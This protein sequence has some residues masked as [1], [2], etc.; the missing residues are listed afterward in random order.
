MEVVDGLPAVGAGVHG[1]AVAVLGETFLPSEVANDDPHASDE[2]A[3]LAAQ[4]KTVRPLEGTGKKRKSSREVDGGFGRAACLRSKAA[5]PGKTLWQRPAGA[6]SSRAG[7]EAGG[8][9]LPACF[10][11]WGM[12]TVD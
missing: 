5:G 12:S 6:A 1:H 2:G 7:A 10:L 3:V 11:Q 9:D 4:G 8:R